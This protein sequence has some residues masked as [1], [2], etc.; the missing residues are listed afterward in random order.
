MPFNPFEIESLR[1]RIYD[2]YF[3][4]T[5]LNRFEDQSPGKGILDS[6][7]TRIEAQESFI[8][9]QLPRSNPITA[10]GPY[11]DQWLNFLNIQR[12]EP[13]RA[14]ARA[15]DKVVRLKVS[16]GGNFG[17]LNGGSSIV[18]NPGDITF[19]GD[20]RVFSNNDFEVLTVRYSLATTTT[21]NPADSEVWI[22]VLADGVGEQYRLEIGQLATHDYTAYSSFG[23]IDLVVENI[24]SITNGYDGDSDDVVGTKMLRQ[25]V[26]RSD[27][28]RSQIE[29][30]LFDLDSVED[31]LILPKRSGPGTVDVFLDASAFY[32]PFSVLQDAE[33]ALSSIT[34]RGVEIFI[35]RVRRLGVSLELDVVF[36]NTIT[37]ERASAIISVIQSQLFSIF[38]SLRIGE[39]LNLSIFVDSF[40][41]A[42]NEI[43]YIGQNNLYFNKAYMFEEGVG[44][45][46]IRKEIDQLEDLSPNEFTRI[47]LE[48]PLLNPILIR[49]KYA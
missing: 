21:L 38:N 3:K 31:Y 6:F 2:E 29:N 32:I 30:I 49:R 35:D 1:T 34:D 20:S 16:N 12:K 47:V 45:K 9:A 28:I 18:L 39:S 44:G 23:N 7:L 33:E 17:D 4:E 42:F 26:F 41:R 14:F 24:S 27:G 13:T 19:F 15:I 37:E 22:D 8:G 48:T 43:Q 11:L 25:S 40:Y 36:K 46:R 10:T 5:N